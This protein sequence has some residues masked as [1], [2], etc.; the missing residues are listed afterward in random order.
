MT[1]S[2]AVIV[3]KRRMFWNVRARPAFMILSG[4]PPVTSAPSNMT[5]PS[6]GL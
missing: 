1:F 3:P 4:R 2:R 5:R 6:V